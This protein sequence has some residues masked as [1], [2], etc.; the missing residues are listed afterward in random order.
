M[1]RTNL[2]YGRAST[3]AYLKERRDDFSRHPTSRMRADRAIK[4]IV[5]Q[6][7]DRK[8]MRL[9]ERLIKATIY[10]DDKA[11]FQIEN[12]IRAYEKKFDMI[13]KNRY[14]KRDEDE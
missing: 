10:Q 5:A 4:N 1:D 11:I 9:R 14:T 2:M 6:L 8:L 13:E 7:R 12:Q 3:L